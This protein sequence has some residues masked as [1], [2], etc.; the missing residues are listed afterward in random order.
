M[1][2]GGRSEGRDTVAEFQAATGVAVTSII[3][4]QDVEALLGE[5]GAA[6]TEAARAG[7]PAS[8]LEDIRSYRERYGVPCP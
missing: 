7:A 4:L 5:S 3:T 1:A 8:L 2:G 6:G